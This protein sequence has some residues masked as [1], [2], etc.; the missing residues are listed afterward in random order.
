L[1]EDGISF[2]T[3]QDSLKLRLLWKIVAHLWSWW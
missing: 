2:N 1:P 3:G